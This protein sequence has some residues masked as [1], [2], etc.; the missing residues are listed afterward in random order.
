M[1]FITAIS[2]IQ[3]KNVDYSDIQNIYIEKA[4]DNRLIKNLSLNEFIDTIKYIP[5][6][7][8]QDCYIDEIQKIEYYNSNYYIWDY[9]KILKFNSQGKFV[10][11]I[12]N[13]GNG[14][15]EYLQ[16][17]GIIIRSDTLFVNAGFK[18]VAFDTEHGRYLDAYPFPNR[19]FFD[20]IST[21]FVTFNSDTGFIEF[22]D[23]NGKI[24]DS[25][26]Y[27]RYKI[28]KTDSDLIIYPF[29]NIFFG[30]NESLKISTSH[31]DTIFELTN[32]HKLIAR[33]NV[34]LGK[35]KL[36]D[37]KRFEYIGNY[38]EFDKETKKFVRT[39]YLET[40]N[41]LFIQFGKWLSNCN[42][43]P[44]GLN[45]QKADMIGLGIFNKKN[46]EFSFIS[47]DL[48]NYPCF[49]PHFS[50]RENCV[51]SFVNAMEAINFFE[52]SNN[53]NN[54]CN[55]FTRAIKDLKMEDNPILIIAEMKD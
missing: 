40:K 18:I 11:K 2:C 26:N 7:T 35:Y 55:S 37:N 3:E 41:F 54:L 9:N 47:Q 14:P 15:E 6:E 16:N 53:N 36:P 21:G 10:C 51:I 20:K 45:D 42:Y 5:L 33:Y 50:D 49:Y 24:L 31:N 43:L 30:T 13:R 48:E 1:L 17:R 29:H 22:I 52:Q 8:T 44:F 23:K 12:G 38:D 28:E 27:E 19:I 4:L 32:K 25:L 39:A 34:D 46:G